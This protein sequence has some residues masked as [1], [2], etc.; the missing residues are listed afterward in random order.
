MDVRMIHKINSTL[1]VT[2][3]NSGTSVFSEFKMPY[4]PVQSKAS[5]FS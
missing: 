3:F 4:L 5:V 2:H 1:P